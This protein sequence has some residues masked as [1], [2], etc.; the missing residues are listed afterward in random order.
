MFKQ[1]LEDQ[2]EF[3]LVNHRHSLLV[4]KR[5]SPLNLGIIVAEIEL[6]LVRHIV[7][8]EFIVSLS[9]AKDL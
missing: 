2:G 4:F 7:F 5:V 9:A 8:F 6:V 3:F 1:L